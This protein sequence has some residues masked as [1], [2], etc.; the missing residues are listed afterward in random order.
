METTKKQKMD[1]QTT[2]TLLY[3]NIP[4]YFNSYQRQYG[5]DE[6]Q[7]SKLDEKN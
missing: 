6:K 1:E 7:E 3:S 2:E 4:W 5:R